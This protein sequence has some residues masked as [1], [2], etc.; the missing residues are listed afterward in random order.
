VT[1]RAIVFVD[2]NNWYHALR[3]IGIPGF[4]QLDLSKI[5]RKLVRH[6]DWQGTRYYIGQVE[7][8][9]SARL[10]SDQRRFLARIQGS[11]ARISVH[12]GRLEARQIENAVAGELE[13]LLGSLPVRID[14][15]V[16]RELV[17]LARR[18]R[19]S[20]IMVEKAVDVMLAVDLVILAERN[21]FDVAFLLSGDGDF[22]PAVEAVRA[23]G[24]KVLGVSPSHGGR[25]GP[26][27]DAFIHIDRPWLAGCR[28]GMDTQP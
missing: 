26:K 2:G 20:T 22:I 4:G 19:R 8:A 9:A 21:Q 18:H 3:A 12:L 6:R 5:S 11:D 17:A 7:R 27:C 10:Y 23:L 24:K 13:Q 1:E 25:L 14:R 15:R 16:Y 28:I